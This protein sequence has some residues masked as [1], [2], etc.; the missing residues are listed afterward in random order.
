MRA[1]LVVEPAVLA[2]PALAKDEISI[3][4]SIEIIIQLAE[5]V[6]NHDFGICLLT[7]AENYLIEAGLYPVHSSMSQS[8]AASGLSHVYTTEDIRR[9]VQGILQNAERLEHSSGI[10]FLIPES[11]RTQPDIFT[12]R[13]T[14]ALK[15]SLEVTLAHLAL[16]TERAG[17]SNV[18][19]LLADRPSNEDVEVIARITDITPPLNDDITSKDV[20]ITVGFCGSV[21][22]FAEQLDGNNL[23]HLAENDDEIRAAISIKA[24]TIRKTSGCPAPKENC[25]K[26]SIGSAFFGTMRSCQAHPSGKFGQVTFE[27]AARLIAKS[28]TETPKKLYK[29][30]SSSQREDVVRSDGAVGWRLHVTKSSE[31]IRLMFWRKKD[32]SVELANVCPKSGVSIH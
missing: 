11:I 32:G 3:A 29:L 19:S 21:S 6:R 18:Q 17:K 25:H 8:L 23:W 14:G 27:T 22:E 10:D 28:E 7:E 1:S 2:M 4:R 20:S 26:F 12:G 31:G 5:A 30:S 24:R 15:E 16:L 13:S 9:S